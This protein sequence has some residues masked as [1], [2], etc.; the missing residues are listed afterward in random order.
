MDQSLW[1]QSNNVGEESAE[2]VPETVTVTLTQNPGEGQT[3]I[4]VKEQLILYN[5][6]IR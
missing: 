3:S 2:P 1:Q 6:W 4:Y 5:D